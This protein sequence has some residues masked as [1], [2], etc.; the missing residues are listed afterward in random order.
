MCEYERDHIEEGCSITGYD[1]GILGD[2]GNRAKGGRREECCG[3]ENVYPS[4]ERNKTKGG[5]RKLV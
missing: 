5:T 2:V 4:D 1:L 3:K